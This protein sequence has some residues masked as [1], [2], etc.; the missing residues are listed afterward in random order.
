[1]SKPV[2]L[3]KKSLRKYVEQPLPIKGCFNCKYCTESL[4]DSNLVYPPK[5]NFNCK[6]EKPEFG[7]SGNVYKY[8][9]C[10]KYKK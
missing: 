7:Y 2:K 4:Q 6:F 8:G 1:M 10:N 3:I 9:I 5:Y